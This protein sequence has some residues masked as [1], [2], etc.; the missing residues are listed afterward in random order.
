MTGGGGG[1]GGRPLRG[2]G[3][4]WRP[5]GCTKERKQE[6]RGKE[7]DSVKLDQTEGAINVWKAEEKKN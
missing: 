3:E 5:V 4:W 1:G 6:G 7:G 2:R